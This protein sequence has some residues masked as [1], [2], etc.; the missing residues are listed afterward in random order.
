MALAWSPALWAKAEAPDVRRAAQGHAVQ[1]VVEEPAGAG[2]AGQ[3]L[4]GD[5]GLQA[6][7][8][9]FLQQER[10]D[11][12]GQVGIAA[13]F[14]Q[15]VQRALDLAGAG[16]DGG[17]RVGDRVAGVVVAVDAEVAAGDA[18]GDD[19]CRDAADLFG[20]GA[21]VGVAQDDPAGAGGVGGLQA[22]EGVGRVGAVAVEEMLGVEEGFAAPGD[23][24]GD[25]GGDGGEVLVEGGAQGGGDVEVVG[26]ADEADGRGLGVEDRGQDVVVLGRA[27]DAG[28]H[29]EGGEGGAGLGRGAEEFAV[30]GV[31]AGP[32]AFDVVD[33][34]G[35]EG[36]GDL[37]LLG[38]RELDALGL[39]AVAEGGVEEGEA[40]GGHGRAWVWASELGHLGRV[41]EIN[42][43]RGRIN[44]DLR[45]VRG[46]DR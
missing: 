16:E 8:E 13:A 44:L 28:G 3:R 15:A 35:I 32:A 42:G 20:Q 33:P 18:G 24:V 45:I 23:G 40:L 29:A 12:G 38:G 6:A 17:Q 9:G 39:L 1:D 27:A 2:E 19:L 34:Q 11:Q 14:A 36:A 43:L 21:A 22:G 7:G 30:G 31:G 46:V 4:R 37:G 10:R 25:G 5:A 41:R 26:L